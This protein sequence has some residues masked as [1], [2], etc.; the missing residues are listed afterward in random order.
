M[1][2]SAGGLWW[3]SS[4]IG[5]RATCTWCIVA[6]DWRACPRQDWI[7]LSWTKVDIE[8]AAGTP[9][10]RPVQWVLFVSLLGDLDVPADVTHVSQIAYIIHHLRLHLPT[11]F[12]RRFLP[13]PVKKENICCCNATL[14]TGNLWEL[15]KTL[16]YFTKI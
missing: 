11:Q 5:H 8:D 6:L 4:V 10:S 3:R 2:V 15:D 14:C 16:T 9:S 12:R 7:D 13:K 1:L